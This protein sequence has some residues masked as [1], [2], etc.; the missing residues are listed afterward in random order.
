MLEAA[1]RVAKNTDAED[2][3]YKIRWRAA[4]KVGELSK[5][6]SKAQGQRSDLGTSGGKPRKL[7]ILK[8]AGIGPRDASDFERLSEVPRDEF[9]AALATKSVRDLIDKPAPVTSDALGL[10]GMMHDFERR[11]LKQSPEVFMSTMTETMIEDVVR[12]APL[13]AELPLLSLR[14]PFNELFGPLFS[15]AFLRKGH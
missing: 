13:A 11:W 1:A 15:R 4:D 14:L 3:A 8:E 9:E 10:Y 5:K 7:D 2:R 6:I 12:V